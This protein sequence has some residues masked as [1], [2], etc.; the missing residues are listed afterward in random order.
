[1]FMDTNAAS[2][3]NPGYTRRNA[4]ANGNGTRLIRLWLNHPIGF[5]VARV[6]ID[7]GLIRA[8]IGAAMRVR[9][10]GVAG[11]SD[12]AMRATAASAAGPGWQTAIACAPGPITS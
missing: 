10:R 1:M 3:M 9:L 12:S 8:S 4:P 5:E 7:V 6:L 11:L 2:C